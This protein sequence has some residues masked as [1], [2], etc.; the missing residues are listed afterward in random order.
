MTPL[1][2]TANRES[3]VTIPCYQM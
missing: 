2:R 1:V 3:K